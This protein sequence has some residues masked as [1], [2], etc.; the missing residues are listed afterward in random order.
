MR[1]CGARGRAVPSPRAPAGRSRPL[2]HRPG[3]P[4][5]SRTGRAVP[6]PRAPAGRSR[7][8]AHPPGGPVPSRT[9]RAA[10]GT[11]ASPRPD[12]RTHQTG[13]LHHQWPLGRIRLGCS[14][15]RVP[16]DPETPLQAPRPTPPRSEEAHGGEAGRGAQTQPRVRRAGGAHGQPPAAPLLQAPPGG[17][18]AARAAPHARA[19]PAPRPARS[20]D[21]PR[22]PGAPRQA[23]VA[24]AGLRPSPRAPAGRGSPGAPPSAAAGRSGPSPPRPRRAP[25]RALSRPPP[26]PARRSPPAAPLPLPCGDAGPA[27]RARGAQ[28][29]ARP[30]C[31]KCQ[32]TE[33]AAGSVGE[34]SAADSRVH[35]GDPPAQVTSPS[36]HRR[37]PCILRVPAIYDDGTRCPSL[38]HFC[39]CSKLWPRFLLEALPHI[40]WLICSPPPSKSP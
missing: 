19:P 30:G 27:D 25:P 20:W 37:A 4:V 35:V 5:P 26:R 32:S 11:L 18:R 8:L 38:Y 9:R 15:G 12:V 33:A 14:G 16:S 40:P 1:E 34:N 21:R 23:A 17:R 39:F 6:S 28:L 10:A 22:A 36:G 24:R 31:R 13:M 2:A 29:A 3:G 7:P